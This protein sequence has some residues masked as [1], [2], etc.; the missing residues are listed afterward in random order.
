MYMCMSGVER[1]CLSLLLSHLLVHD[2]SSHD[3]F[4]EDRPDVDVAHGDGRLAFFP[5]KLLEK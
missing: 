3:V 1:V 5:Q 2:I 4:L